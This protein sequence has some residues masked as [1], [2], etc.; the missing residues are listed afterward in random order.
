VI[1]VVL[2]ASA[3]L[4]ELGPLPDTV[5]LVPH[6]AGDDL[7]R[8]QL[9]AEVIVFGAEQSP[10]VPRLAEFAALRF[11]QTLSAGV[12][13]LLPHVPAGVTVANAGNTHDIPVAE[14]VVAMLLAHQHLLPRFLDAQREQ[15]WD[16]QGNALTSAPEDTPGDDLE[17]K[18][19]LVVGHGSIGRAVQARLE[20]F[21]VEVI[22]ITRHGRHGTWTPDRLMDLVRDVEAVVILTPLTAESTGLIS[23]DV[24]AA[25]ADHTIVVN[26]GRGPVL[27]HVALEAELRTG[28]LRAALDVTDPEPLPD[29]HS[30]WSAPNVIITP[31]VAGSSRRWQARAYRVAGDQLRRYAAGEPLHNIRHDY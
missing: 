3:L 24:L 29:G 21:G 19:V 23:A 22:G 28:R 31:H 12:E 20:P 13:R 9:G 30:L 2:P 26:A 7:S 6:V 4:D 10:L 15:R 14:W 5:R 8:E 11:I 18:R 1:D 16:H 25:M 17:S 27:D